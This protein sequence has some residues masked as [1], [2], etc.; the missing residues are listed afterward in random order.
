MPKDKRCTK[1]SHTFDSAESLNQHISTVHSSPSCHLCHLCAD[2]FST[3]TQL[4]RHVE[5]QHCGK[6]ESSHPYVCALCAESPENGP[7]SYTVQGLLTKHLQHAHGVPRTAA[8]NMARAAAPQVPTSDSEN[9]T[10]QVPDSPSCSTKPI[11]RLF[12]SGETAVYQCSRCDFSVEDRVSFVTHA[13]EHRPTVA[14][15]VQ[16]KECAASFTVTVALHRHLRL[17]HRIDVD[18][19]TY[20]Q[21]NGGAA[22]CPTPD[23]SFTDDDLG[24]PAKLSNTS[25]LTSSGGRS[26]ESAG[27]GRKILTSTKGD[28]DDDAP[29]ECTVCYRVLLSKQLLRA[30][31]RTHG[32]AFIQHTR[33]R[34]AA[35]SPAARSPPT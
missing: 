17:I 1:C 22:R 29:A 21:E 18:I 33:R 20:L 28:D 14:G 12:V 35:I 26:T 34:L 6:T 10:E 5:V 27:N 8:A 7:V 23:S 9:Q 16:C 13:V 4:Q 19:E 25:S 24:S 32:I 30:H 31:L 2:G 11:K 3:S 15:A